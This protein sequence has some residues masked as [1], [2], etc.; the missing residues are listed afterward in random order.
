MQITQVNLSPCPVH[1]QVAML[2]RP[3][4]DEIVGRH[5]YTGGRLHPMIDGTLHKERI[6]AES[7]NPEIAILPGTA[8]YNP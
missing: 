2:T 5:E 3:A 1:K 7:Q 8:W 6:L 4:S